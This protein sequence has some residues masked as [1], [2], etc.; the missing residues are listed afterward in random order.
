MQ[1]YNTKNIVNNLLTIKNYCVDITMY[2]VITTV[3][4]IVPIKLTTY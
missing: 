1:T 4:I 2:F 3:L